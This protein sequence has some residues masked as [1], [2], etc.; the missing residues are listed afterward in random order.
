[1][2]NNNEEIYYLRIASGTVYLKIV[3]DNTVDVRGDR[4]TL[5]RVKLM[6]FLETARL[7]GLKAGRL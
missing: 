7:L 6:D 4:I 1:M 2:D 5:Q 3:D